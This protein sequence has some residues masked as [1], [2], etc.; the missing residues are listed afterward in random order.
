MGYNYFEKIIADGIKNSPETMEFLRSQALEILQECRINWENSCPREDLQEIEACW[1]YYHV[2]QKKFD[3]YLYE[4]ILEAYNQ[5]PYFNSEKL[6]N[7]ICAMFDNIICYALENVKYIEV[8]D[9]MGIVIEDDYEFRKVNAEKP[10][11]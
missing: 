6:P 10:I 7:S 9:F 5:L 8:H 2:A 4:W 3:K 1:D 11:A